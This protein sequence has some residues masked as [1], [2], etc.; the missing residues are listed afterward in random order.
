MQLSEIAAAV[1]GRA[2]GRIEVTAICTD[3]RAIEPGC[4]FI[5]LKGDRFD[6]HDFVEEAL[7]KGAAAILCSEPLSLAA[8]Q[9]WVPDTGVAL[10]RLA[11]YYR[12]K[13]TLPVVG[14]TG[15]VGKTTTKEMVFAV[16]SQKYKTLKNEGNL[17]NAIGLPLTVFRLDASYEA[18]VLEMGM[19]DFGEIA[20]LTRVAQPD[21]G[22]L[23]NIGVSHIETLGSRENILKAKLEILEG[24]A[25]DAP[26]LLNL[27]DPLLQTVRDTGRPMITYGIHNPDCQY[28]GVNIAHEGLSTHFELAYNGKRSTVTLPTVGEHNVYN[29]LAA[30]AAG[31][32][33]G[34]PPDLAAQGLQG[35][36]PAGMR[37]RIRDYQGIT[38]I[39]DC[40]NAAPDSMR[41]SLGTL[42][43]LPARK[44]VAVLGDMLEL[45]EIRE[46]AHRD[47]GA[48]AADCK[49]DA[50]FAYGEAA[51]GYIEGAAKAGFTHCRH[52]MEKEALTG[53]LL[54]TLAEGDAV[55][56]K[57]S[58]GM[59]LEEVIQ[60]LYE[61][62]DKR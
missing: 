48:F 58:R 7:A 26:L 52:F 11:A 8:P 59:K 34:V 42:R 18:A 6:G 4:L 12:R 2:Q 43:D 45:G 30:F 50:L 21:I 28:R 56:F 31:Q 49:P 14:L 55:L 37:Q 20:A 44:R 33:L 1:E 46:Q 10:L 53:A 22:I 47:V 40:Y 38:V 23:T 61:R 35:Y 54:Q 32:F 29:A 19:A 60:R 15:S 62:W 36:E 57:G 41:A 13:F 5:C 3:T 24:M 17:N 25:P 39:E 9:V 27:D 16:L 51:A